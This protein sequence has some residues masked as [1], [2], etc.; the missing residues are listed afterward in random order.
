[1]KEKSCSSNIV[2]VKGERNKNEA[3]ETNK[4]GNRTI[5]ICVVLIKIIFKKHVQ[6]SITVMRKENIMLA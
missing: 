2:T 3:E 6:I 1:M 4:R 5:Y